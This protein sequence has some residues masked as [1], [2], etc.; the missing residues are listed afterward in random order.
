[1][2]Y[3]KITAATTKAASK[4]YTD[5]KIA[6]KA[7][8][9]ERKGQ[10]M[11]EIFAKIRQECTFGEPDKKGNCDLIYGANPE[12]GEKGNVI[13]WVNPQRGMGWI[14][15]KAYDKYVRNVEIKE[16]EPLDYHGMDE[17]DDDNYDDDL[18]SCSCL[19]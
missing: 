2:A 10:N 9:G 5:E 18:M 12:T 14:D 6:E 8:N 16:P 3:N 1:M 19:W 15:D 13:G 11:G 7:A 17:Y 4:V